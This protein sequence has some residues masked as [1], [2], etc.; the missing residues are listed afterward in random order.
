MQHYA[1]AANSVGLWAS[2]EIICDHLFKKDEPLLELGCGAGRISLGLWDIGYR[3][4]YAIDYS[5]EMIEE[6]RKFGRILDCDIVFRH[7]D[8]L[9]LPNYFKLVISRQAGVTRN[10]FIQPVSFDPAF[11]RLLAIQMHLSALQEWQQ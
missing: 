2:E 8:A 11:F 5:R 9:D 10:S 4:I 1:H 7:G 3:N 6:A